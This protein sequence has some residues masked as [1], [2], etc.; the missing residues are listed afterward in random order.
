MHTI[1]SGGLSQIPESLLFLVFLSRLRSPQ[2]AHSKKSQFIL[3]VNPI[4]LARGRVATSSLFDRISI[5]RSTDTT[6]LNAFSS[7]SLSQSSTFVISFRNPRSPQGIEHR[8]V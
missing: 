3:F 8:P 7:A 6:F 2:P 4:L 5:C 1:S